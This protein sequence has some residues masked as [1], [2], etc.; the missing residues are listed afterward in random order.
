MIVVP[1]FNAPRAVS[2]LTGF[3]P[4]KQSWKVNSSRFC[5]YAEATARSEM[6]CFKLFEYIHFDGEDPDPDLDTDPFL[7]VPARLVQSIVNDY[8]ELVNS[9]TRYFAVFVFPSLTGG[10]LPAEVG[11]VFHATVLELAESE[12][13][14]FE[15][16]VLALNSNKFEN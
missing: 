12:V 11:E 6:P 5:E 7:E 2:F 8:I 9:P 15:N 4:S 3:N 16:Q 10:G 13:D 1:D 14:D